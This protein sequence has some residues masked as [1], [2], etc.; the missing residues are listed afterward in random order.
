MVAELIISLIRDLGL[1]AIGAAVLTYIA[2]HTVNQYFEKQL[3]SYQAE[4]SREEVR[5]AELHEERANVMK[6]LYGKLTEFDEDMRILVDP[7][8]SRGETDRD[9]KLDIAAESVEE[10][11]RYYLR[12][13]I[14]LPPDVCE[15]MDDLLKT[16]RDMFHEF[17]LLRIHDRKESALEERERTEKWLENWEDLTT[18]E[19][20][21]LKLKLETQFRDLLGVDIEDS[22]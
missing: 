18:D 12:N 22:D 6:D 5:F 3:K 21:E 7:I 13:K 4:L 16:Y 17:A 1:I 9:E 14:Y 2:R 20:P 15:T 8:V 19:V 10:L 11:R